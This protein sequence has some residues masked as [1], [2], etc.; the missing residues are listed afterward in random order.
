MHRPVL[1]YSMVSTTRTKL[2]IIRQNYNLIDGINLRTEAKRDD[3]KK[4]HHVNSKTMQ[5]NIIMSILRRCK[6]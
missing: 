5:R 2:E 3:A 6:K 4:Y 1:F